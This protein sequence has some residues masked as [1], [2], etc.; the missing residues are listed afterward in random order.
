MFSLTWVQIESHRRILAFHFA[1]LLPHPPVSLITLPFYNR[2]SIFHSVCLFVHKFVKERLSKARVTHPPFDLS[3]QSKYFITKTKSNLK[4]NVHFKSSVNCIV[5]DKLAISCCVRVYVCLRQMRK[6][7]LKKR[8]T[9]IFCSIDTRIKLNEI[10]QW[11]K[12]KRC[13]HKSTP[14]TELDKHSYSVWLRTRACAHSY[15]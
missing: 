10:S 8:V 7:R 4:R 11:T 14:I 2:L 1:L 15:V 5:V 9:Y 6:A 3:M 13:G 12:K